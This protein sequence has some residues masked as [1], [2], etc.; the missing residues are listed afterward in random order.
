MQNKKMES[1]ALKLDLNKFKKLCST[2]TPDIAVMVRGRHAIGKTEGV[3]QVASLIRD[4]FYKDPENCARMV[5]ALS[6]HKEVAKKIEKNGGVWTYEMGVPIIEMRL[7]QMQEGDIVGLPFLEGKGTEFR[8]VTWLLNCEEFPVVLF[9]DELNRASRQVEQATFQLADSKAFYGHTLHKGTRI[10][11]AVNIGDAYTVEDMDPAAISRY[12]V[13][14]LDPTKEEWL[15]YIKNFAHPLTYSFL[16]TNPQYIEYLGEIEPNVKTND[17]RAWVRLDEQLQVNNLFDQPNELLLH[18][19][20]SM[21]GFTT[22]NAFYEFVRTADNLTGEDIILNWKKLKSDLPVDEERK[23]KQLMLYT[24]KVQ[25]MVANK[26]ITSERLMEISEKFK[27][28]AKDIPGEMLI[29]I[30]SSATQELSNIIGSILGQEVARAVNGGPQVEK[31]Q[32][33][34]SAPPLIPRIRR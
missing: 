3:R 17:R 11:V 16:K 23:M 5:K 20:A 10:Y 24:I 25:G 26:L 1:L 12:A 15:N 7:S 13:V 31:N 18:M 29:S 27:I 21:L 14:D 34:T 8:P 2:F 6:S 22:G 19:A 32:T 4:D 33:I 28:F 30:Y 9:L